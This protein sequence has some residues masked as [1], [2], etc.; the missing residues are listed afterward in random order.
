LSDLR[1]DSHKQNHS[2]GLDGRLAFVE[3]KRCGWSWV[4]YEKWSSEIIGQG[5]METK[6]EAMAKAEEAI[7]G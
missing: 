2:C 7:R 1:W 5:L 4:A 3:G 6:A